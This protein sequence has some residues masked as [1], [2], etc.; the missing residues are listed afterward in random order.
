M[1]S[2]RFKLTIWALLIAGCAAVLCILG[3]LRPVAKDVLLRIN[4]PWHNSYLVKHGRIATNQ[5]GS[6]ESA[7]INRH[8]AGKAD[9][10]LSFPRYQSQET[11]EAYLSSNSP[12]A[13]GKDT[14][15]EQAFSKASIITRLLGTPSREQAIEDGM[16]ELLFTIPRLIHHEGRTEH[17]V[18]I[19]SAFGHVFRTIVAIPQGQEKAASKVALCLP[20]SSMENGLEPLGYTG[21]NNNYA[22][23]LTALGYV[24]ITPTLL[25]FQPKYANIKDGWDVPYK[26]IQADN[27]H[28]SGFAISAL[29]IKKVV[30]F[31][32]AQDL[33]EFDKEEVS[34][35]GLSHGATMASI[36]MALD[37]RLKI[38]FSV[39]GGYH[40]DC[41]PGSSGWLESIYWA[42]SGL[43]YCKE[44]GNLGIDFHD[45][46]TLAHPRRIV[47][48]NG[49]GDSAGKLPQSQLDELRTLYQDT[50]Q[51]LQI[52]MDTPLG[53][54][55]PHRFDANVVSHIIK[56][57]QRAEG[58]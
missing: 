22:E 50:P 39:G 17:H 44:N 19:R 3:P 55:N 58:K 35:G 41:T 37:P 11:Y 36:A 26:L 7:P 15:R 29:D 27:P 51:R 14:I 10:Y 8:A 21:S 30:D 40:M 47:L 9:D 48:F 32:F 38:L 6:A 42:G 1:A 4:G 54:G 53:D 2:T 18:Y 12:D 33:F 13:D 56:A 16:E 43:S 25:G 20:Q 52:L 46:L 28:L 57:V 24:T 23:Q 34:I 49:A 31:L 5:V 45:I